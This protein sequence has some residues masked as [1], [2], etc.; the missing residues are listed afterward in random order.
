MPKKHAALAGN[1]RSIAGP[2]PRKRFME[3]PGSD[4]RLKQSKVPLVRPVG[5]RLEP[6]LHGVERDSD[7][8]IRDA[9]T[10]AGGRI[11]TRARASIPPRG[12][13]AAPPLRTQPQSRRRRSQTARTST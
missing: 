6:R 2:A 10:A 1:A 12:G 11:S 13:A 4:T 5:R 3:P 8:P 9:W 7:E